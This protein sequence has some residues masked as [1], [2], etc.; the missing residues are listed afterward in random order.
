MCGIFGILYRDGSRVPDTGC[1]ERSAAMMEHRGPDG[2]GIYREPGIGL[3]HTRL[4]LVDLDV[5]SNQPMWDEQGQCC[6]VFNGEIYN[7]RELRDELERGGARFRTTS[8][9]EVLL[10]SLIID[11]PERTLRR[12]EG[13]FAFAFYDKRTRTVLLARDRFGIKPLHIYQDDERLIFASEVKAM[14]PWVQLRPDMMQV[15]RYLMNYGAP[16]RNSSIYENVDIAPAG[17]AITIEVGSAPKEGSFCELPDMYDR[18]L[19][20]RLDRLTPKQAVDHVDEMLNRS[21]ERMLFAD[22][23]VGALCSGGVDS[24]ILMAIAAKYH[25]NLAIFHADVVGPQSEYEAACALAKHLKLDLLTVKTTDEDFI[26]RTPEVLYHYERPFYGLPHSVPFMLVS[27]LVHEHRIKAVLTGEGSDECYLG[28][29]YLALEPLWKFYNRQVERIAR[30]VNRIPVIGH[31]LWSNPGSAVSLVPDMLGQFEVA[32]DTRKARSAYSRCLGKSPGLNVRTVDM[33]S[34]HLRTLLHRNDTMGM[35]A[36]LETR[37]PFLD[38]NLVAMAINLPTRFKLRFSPT[39]WERDHPFIRDKWV[40]RSVADRYLPKVLSR[41]KKLGFNVSAYQRM[42]IDRGFFKT[43]FVKD[44]FKLSNGE[45]ELLF[46]SAD[47][48]LEGKLMML[49]IWGQMF[50]RGASQESVQTNL[51]SHASYV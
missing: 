35:R 43:G 27:N 13:M 3:A 51:Q 17:S 44:Y 47:R 15:I 20:E 28:Y 11:G 45:A 16:V 37:F 14:M 2:Y 4:S 31:R 40:L 32:I 39:T 9:T 36:S 33:L 48:T 30:L 38:E 24:S 42:R 6:L 12:L 46:D 21:V 34:N 26:R 29:E 25:N 5:R 41:R 49:E 23:P 10:Q 1:L 7:F 8:D 19:A 18:E 50:F 22:V